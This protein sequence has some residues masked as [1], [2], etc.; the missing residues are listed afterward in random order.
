[1]YK[2]TIDD[3]YGSVTVESD[4][5][6]YLKR[7]QEALDTVRQNAEKDEREKMNRLVDQFFD[8][9]VQNMKAPVKKRGRPVGSTNKASKAK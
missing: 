1:M 9:E 7:V 2:L 6:S 3:S 8:V 5:F 4:N